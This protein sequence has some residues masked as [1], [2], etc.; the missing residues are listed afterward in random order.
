MNK[1]LLTGRFCQTLALFITCHLTPATLCL[2]KAIK[3]TS[4]AAT[5]P[6]DTKQM[7]SVILYL[8]FLGEIRCDNAAPLTR[9][10]LM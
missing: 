8:R 5:A 10:V 2:C 4:E 6:R 3:E 9:Y 1:T 7:P